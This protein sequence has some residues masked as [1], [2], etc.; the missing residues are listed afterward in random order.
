LSKLCL[1]AEDLRKTYGRR[2]VLINVSLNLGQGIIS[3]LGRNG[4]G[5]TTLFN[6]VAGLT[7]PD[8]GV[9]KLGDQTLGSVP[10]HVWQRPI[11]LVPQ[12]T[13]VPR[14]LSVVD[15]VRYSAYLRGISWKKAKPAAVD[16]I[17]QVALSSVA[18]AKVSTLSGGERRRLSLAAALVAEPSVLLLDEPTAG[19]DLFQRDAMLGLIRRTCQHRLVI[20]ATHQID[21]AIDVGGPLLILRQGHMMYFESVHALTGQSSHSQVSSDLVRTAL[22]TLLGV[23]AELTDT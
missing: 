1:F 4:A 2:P 8:G 3:L 22:R 7:S 11:A 17:D 20:V 16:A 9:V 14:W 13:E 23:E 10:L 6:I 12:F 21:D 15:Y 19:L 18:A 5:K